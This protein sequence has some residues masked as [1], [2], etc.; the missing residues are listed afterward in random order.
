MRKKEIKK[1]RTTSEIVFILFSEKKRS[2]QKTKQDKTQH[3]C[4]TDKIGKS[5]FPRKLKN[6][7]ASKKH[8]LFSSLKKN[9][10]LTHPRNTN[11]G[12]LL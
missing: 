2:D 4:F 8:V 9:S 12:D 6:V 7:P 1:E 11:K 3:F 5:V 10:S